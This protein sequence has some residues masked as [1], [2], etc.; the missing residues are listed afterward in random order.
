V[1]RNLRLCSN[2]TGNFSDKNLSRSLSFN[3]KDVIDEEGFNLSPN[4]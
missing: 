2:C 1:E 3:W 4:W